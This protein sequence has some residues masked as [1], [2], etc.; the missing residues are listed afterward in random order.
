MLELTHIWNNW[1]IKNETIWNNIEQNI[2]TNQ[3]IYLS[4]IIWKK[5]Q[6]LI[7]LR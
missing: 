6:Y 7:I 2:I 5:V 4:E 3:G 1:R